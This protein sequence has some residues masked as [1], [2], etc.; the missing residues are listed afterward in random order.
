MAAQGRYVMAQVAQGKGLPELSH[1]SNALSAAAYSK[2]SGSKYS[3]SAKKSSHVRSHTYSACPSQAS[4]AKSSQRMRLLSPGNIYFESKLPNDDLNYSL[5]PAAKHALR[6]GSLDPRQT[7]FGKSFNRKMRMRDTFTKIFP[8]YSHGE[9]TVSGPSFTQTAHFYPKQND[10]GKPM[11]DID[12]QY[13]HKIDFMKEYHES[14]L[15][16]AGM[17]VNR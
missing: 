8:T 3:Q 6:D 1:K 14:M 16:I 2:K 11:Q 13:T 10:L 5:S 9:P 4:G 15:K 7:F 12:R 17:R